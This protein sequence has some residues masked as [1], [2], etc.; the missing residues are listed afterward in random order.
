MPTADEATLALHS[1]WQMISNA[2]ADVWLIDGDGAT[3]AVTGVP[4]ASLNVVYSIRTNVKTA[5]VSELLDQLAATRLPH[6]LQLRPGTDESVVALAKTRGMSRIDDEP[7]MTLDDGSRLKE[8]VSPRATPGMTVRGL[9]P[10]EAA[11]HAAMV[12]DAF[13]A[14]AGPLAQCLVPPLLETAGVRCYV[15]EADGHVVATGMGL[16]VGGVVGVFNIGTAA[17]HRGRGYG[18]AI[19]ARA[20]LDAFNGG[21]RWAVLKASPMGLPVYQRLGFAT[22]ERWMCWQTGT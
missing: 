12:A 11:I 22:L 7:L 2:L 13:S 21:A 10:E 8:A 15:G 18:A 17:P 19:T 1:M 4:L 20:V 16:T 9:A 3:A 14:P 6:S 5:V